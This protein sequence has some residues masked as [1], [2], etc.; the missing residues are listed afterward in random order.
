MAAKARVEGEREE[1]GEGWT[2]TMVNTLTVLIHTLIHAV[3]G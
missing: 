2:V 3:I 1:G